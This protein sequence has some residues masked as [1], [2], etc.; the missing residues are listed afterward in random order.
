MVKDQE[1]NAPEKDNE[2]SNLTAFQ[3][4]ERKMRTCFVGNIPLDTSPKQL[5]KLF[6]KYGKI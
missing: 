5:K 1:V 4:K 3:I 2:D 6:G